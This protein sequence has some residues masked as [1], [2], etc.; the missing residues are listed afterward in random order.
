MSKALDALV[1]AAV[2]FLATLVVAVFA[3]AELL[4]II[5]AVVDEFVKMIEYKIIDDTSDKMPF[6]YSEIAQNLD[7]D[8][9][10]LLQFIQ[11]H[12]N[13]DI[14]I[15][16]KDIDNI[17]HSFHNKNSILKIDSCIIE[18]LIAIFIKDNIF[19]KISEKDKYLYCLYTVIDLLDVSNTNFIPISL[20]ILDFIN[21]SNILFF[22]STKRSNE[23]NSW[24]IF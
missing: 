18:D 6:I 17:F 19:T 2:E 5:A 12:K 13:S 24:H 7:D 1:L 8:D 3:V 4:V 23:L 22:F 15:S 14:D 20:Q 9:Y 10:S 21:F 16:E 11:K